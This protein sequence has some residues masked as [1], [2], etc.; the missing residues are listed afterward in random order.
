MKFLRARARLF[1]DPYI[2]FFKPSRPFVALLSSCWSMRSA[3]R[4]SLRLSTSK[5]EA[6]C[7]L[8]SPQRASR[9]DRVLGSCSIKRIEIPTRV[10]VSLIRLGDG[11]V[12]KFQVV[13]DLPGSFRVLVRARINDQRRFSRSLVLSFRA[14]ARVSITLVAVVLI[15]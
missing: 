8:L 7:L 2:T 15:A 9:P 11:F 4:P 6:R 12:S 5:S 3:D 10:L 14:V 1:Q 13:I